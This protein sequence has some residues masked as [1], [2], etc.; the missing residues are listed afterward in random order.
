MAGSDFPADILAAAR[1]AIA[2]L[3]YDRV[4]PMGKKA[5]VIAAAIAAERKRCA[6]AARLEFEGFKARGLSSEAYG[7]LIAHRAI[8]GAHA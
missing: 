6:E 3:P 7:A 5:A 1:E 8:L 2:G 4:D